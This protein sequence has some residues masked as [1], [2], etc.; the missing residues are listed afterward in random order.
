MGRKKIDCLEEFLV[1]VCGYCWVMRKIFDG[2]GSKKMQKE[3]DH[4]SLFY[5]FIKP[6]IRTTDL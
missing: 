3:R 2:F 5:D 4:M 1:S 6:E